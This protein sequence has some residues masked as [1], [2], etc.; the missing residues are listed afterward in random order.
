MAIKTRLQAIATYFCCDVYEAEE[1]RYQST[2]TSMPVWTKGIAFYCV[3]K[4]S[5]KPAVHSDGMEWKWKRVDDN[6]INS[7]GWKIW[8]SE[9]E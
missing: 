5:Q 6:F 3:T 8:K 1:C 7:F 2:R 4:G 9:S